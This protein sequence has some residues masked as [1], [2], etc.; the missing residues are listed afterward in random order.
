VRYH[1]A[2]EA[3]IR[4]RACCM[5]IVGSPTWKKGAESFTR[6]LAAPHVTRLACTKSPARIA[7]P[8]A[9]KPAW[10]ARYP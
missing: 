7:I 6:V 5:R 8:D 9:R 1:A 2:Q 4:V 10:H 3:R